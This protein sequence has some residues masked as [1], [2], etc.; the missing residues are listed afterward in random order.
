M[1]VAVPMTLEVFLLGHLTALGRLYDVTVVANCPD[2]TLAQKLGENIEFVHVGIKREI[3]PFQDSRCLMT[4][5]RL[6]RSRQFMVVHSITPKAGL[7]AMVAARLAGVPIRIHTFTG[8]VWA[9]L[10]GWKRWLL[11]RMDVILARSAT[12]L[13]ADSPSQLSFLRKEGV[14][15][16]LTASVLGKGS[17]SGVNRE[18]FRPRSQARKEIRE[19]LGIAED[20][21]V[22]GFMGRLKRDKGVLDLAQAFQMVFEEHKSVH[23]LV[24]G[25]DEEH[26]SQG[27]VDLAGEAASKMSFVQ[28]TKEPEL[29]LAAIDLLCLPSYR[30]GF[31]S[32]IIEAASCGVPALASRIYGVSDAIV[33]GVTGWMHEC[34]DVGGIASGL[35]HAVE[36]RPEMAEM[37]LRARKRAHQDFDSSSLSEQL[38][39]LYKQLTG[40]TRIA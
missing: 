34:G 5:F 20:A 37:G 9:G 21:M 2:G 31:G 12:R 18:R 22:L 14:V 26:L 15:R 11:K 36:S 23:L 29:Y 40:E 13:L 17:I 24:V 33:E 30:E 39:A 32:V 3:S 16:T 38:V 7:L 28:W 1:V 27:M 4:L 10:K 19:S 8:Q 6:F 25:P 35:K